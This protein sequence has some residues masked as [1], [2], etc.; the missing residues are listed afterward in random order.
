MSLIL[1]KFNQTLQHV[2]QLSIKRLTVLGFTLVL[3]PL[4]AT[5][6]FMAEQTKNVSNEGA[7]T[8]LEVSAL[9]EANEAL[10]L[11]LTKAE[12]FA[13]QFIVLRDEELLDRFSVEHFKAISVIENQFNLM[14]DPK[15]TSALASLTEI[16]SQV[17]IKLPR[18]PPSFDE[19]SETERVFQQI[20]DLNHAI[21]ERSGQLIQ[22]AALEIRNQQQNVDSLIY[23][24]LL[25]I[26]ISIFIA[27]IFTLLITRPLKQLVKQIQVLEQGKFE[28]KIEISG[29]AEV[30]EIANALDI[31]RTRLHA[32]ELQKSSFIRHI[33]HELKTPLAAIREGSSLLDD[34]SLGQLNA[35]QYEVSQIIVSNVSR[36]QQLIE[37][38]L[39]FNIVLDS[40]SLQ[41]SE[42][43]ELLPLI[44]QVISQHRLTLDKK[45]LQ[46]RLDIPAI[47]VYSN[48]KQLAVIIENLVSNAI[49]YV[50]AKRELTISADIDKQ[51]LILKVSDNG[52]GISETDQ[53]RIFEAFYQGAAPDTGDIKSSGLGLTIVKELV[54]RLNGQIDISS[55][56]EPDNHGTTF[57]VT[58]P[59]AIYLEPS[60]HQHN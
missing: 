20:A 52:D 29:S 15:L 17:A 19:L 12:R 21:N 25:I 28:Q 10:T 40:T 33:S 58:L 36:L 30:K 47:A 48:R 24:S 6:V 53:R 34:N 18:L 13:N 8:V 2:A 11:A 42:K 55:S 39:A 50:P 56:Q 49:K 46:L 5:L 27:G 38:L 57:T 44:E 4:L 45:P 54:M 51:A 37:D 59:R 35:S 43:F 3:A 16:L 31:M 60:G 23:K 9:V 7:Q 26:P 32:L 1:T 41:D 22:V 14:Q